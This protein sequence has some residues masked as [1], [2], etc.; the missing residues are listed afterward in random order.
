[1]TAGLDLPSAGGVLLDGQRVGRPGPDRMVVF[2][3][4]SLL[5]W[6]TVR[7]NV[8]LAVDEVM[9]G[10]PRAERKALVEKYVD[11]VGLSHALDKPPGQLSGGMK[12]R[13]AIASTAAARTSVSGSSRR[14]F[15]SISWVWVK[16]QWPTL[17]KR[18]AAS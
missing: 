4:Y 8:A 7:E 15:F 10:L 12:Q 5:P 13:V 9:A 16:S 14:R 3:N 2:Q 1:M 17:P 11:M 18:L 6:L